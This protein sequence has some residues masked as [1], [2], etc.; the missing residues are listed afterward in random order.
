MQHYKKQKK[1]NK[2]KER[3]KR[4]L[5]EIVKGKW[6]YKF[7]GFNI[8]ANAKQMLQRFPIALAQVKGVNTYENLLNEIRKI[9]YPSYQAKEVNK[10]V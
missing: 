2:K 10:K 6:E 3:K 5:H 4:D 9:I 8:L 1:I 7:E